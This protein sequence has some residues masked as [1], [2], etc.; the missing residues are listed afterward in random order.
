MDDERFDLEACL[1][2]L[3][4]VRLE[5]KN[6]LD[7]LNAPRERKAKSKAQQLRDQ[8]FSIYES[9][10]LNLETD[11]CSQH[12]HSEMDWYS[13]VLLSAQVELQWVKWYSTQR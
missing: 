7:A 5:M 10:I 6:A 3:K 2:E 13:R 9:L 1:T 8:I 4:N 12:S 11:S